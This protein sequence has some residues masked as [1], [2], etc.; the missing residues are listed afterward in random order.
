MAREALIV[1][2]DTKTKKSLKK[3]ATEEDR[4]ISQVARRMIEQAVKR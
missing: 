1:Y 3:I 2:I 4:S